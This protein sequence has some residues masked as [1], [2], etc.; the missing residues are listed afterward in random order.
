[1]P[2]APELH[3]WKPLVDDLQGR[4]DKALAM[5]GEQQVDRQRSMGKMPV[6]R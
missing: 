5:G 1:M 4:R 3:N 2:D 6:R